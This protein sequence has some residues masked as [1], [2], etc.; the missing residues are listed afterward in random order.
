LQGGYSYP[1]PG[2]FFSDESQAKSPTRCFSRTFL[3]LQVIHAFAAFIKLLSR[4]E[5]TG[6][7]PVEEGA[8][9]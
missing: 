5:T 9:D 7:K 4:L 2:L 8:L 6:W 3:L 1:L